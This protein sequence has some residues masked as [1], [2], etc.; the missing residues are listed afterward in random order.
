MAPANLK[1]SFSAAAAKE[2][3]EYTFNNLSPIDSYRL[4]IPSK[5]EESYEKFHK[6]DVKSLGANMLQDLIGQEGEEDI[7]NFIRDVGKS[8]VVPNMSPVDKV[9]RMFPYGR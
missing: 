8:P 5:S 1:E 6:K 9:E 3:S 7:L 4:G 2:K